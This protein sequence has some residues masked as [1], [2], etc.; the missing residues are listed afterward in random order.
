MGDFVTRFAP[1]PTGYLHLG[2]AFSAL[3][4]YDAA[5]AAVGRFLLRIED[6]DQGRC[7]PEYEAAIIEDLQ[8]LGLEWE[9]PVRRQSEHFDDY[10]A[11]LDRLRA[12][13]LVYRCFKTR[14]EIAEAIA[15]APH[16][17]PDGPD[18]PAYVG[19]VLTAFEER[20]RLAEGAPFAWR[21][22]M[23][24][25]LDHV[26]GADLSFTEES[27]DGERRRVAARPQIFGDVVIARKDFA[28][29]YH[30]SSVH[31]D[32]LQGTTQVTRGDDLAA[33]AHLHT[34]LQA[35]LGLPRPV[36][37]H[38]HL[39]TDEKGRR[40]AKRDRDATL[41]AMRAAGASPAEI[42]ARLGL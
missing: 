22:T 17:A 40:L 6:I 38:H 35:L 15:R 30:L 33:A 12:R 28:T 14:R 3:T 23:A 41:R 42:R 9:A 20:A 37:R 25:A 24:R 2:H 19:E 10:A 29:S 27:A 26:A 11:A 4:A 31:D 16:L 8:W 34:L 39:I 7:R 36:Y 13:G 32:A 21:L 1:S 5:R 18:G